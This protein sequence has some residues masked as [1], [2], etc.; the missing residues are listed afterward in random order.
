MEQ[1]QAC[2]GRIEQI[3]NSGL[4]LQPSAVFCGWWCGICEGPPVR[5]FFFPKIAFTKQR[6]KPKLSLICPQFVFSQ[7]SD[8]F[9]KCRQFFLTKNGLKPLYADKFT[10]TYRCFRGS[11]QNTLGVTVTESV[12]LLVRHCAVVACAMAPIPRPTVGLL[13]L[14]QH[15]S[16]S[17]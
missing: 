6:T 11:R 8:T 10:D 9:P 4:Q 1:I 12:Q 14:H 5:V 13:C 17:Y 2:R 15:K 16:D 3:I 7:A